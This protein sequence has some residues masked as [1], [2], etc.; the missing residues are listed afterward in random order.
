M[1]AAKNADIVE[2][3]NFVGSGVSDVLKKLEEGLDPKRYM[4][5]YT[6]IHDYCTTQKSCLENARNL[7]SSNSQGLVTFSPSSWFFV[8]E[9]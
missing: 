2:T 7:E 3:W 5:I 8:L 1:C 6:R 9:D 4:D